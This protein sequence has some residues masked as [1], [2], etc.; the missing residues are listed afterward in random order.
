MPARRHTT[1]SNHRS[2]KTARPPSAHQTRPQRGRAGRDAAQPSPAQ[3]MIR[4]LNSA[5]P[6]LRPSHASSVFPS[7][8]QVTLPWPCD[9]GGPVGRLPCEHRSAPTMFHLAVASCLDLR[10]PCLSCSSASAPLLPLG[11]WLP[12]TLVQ[13]CR[14]A[15]QITL[16]RGYQP[17]A[18]I[19]CRSA[20]SWPA[21]NVRSF[22]RS[23]ARA[24]LLYPTGRRS[25]VCHLC[26]EPCSATCG[27]ERRNSFETQKLD[28]R[29]H[30][31]RSHRRGVT[32]PASADGPYMVTAASSLLPY[33]CSLAMGL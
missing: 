3:L 23:L 32:L 13:H 21:A 28:T 12:Q 1:S 33:Y 24:F 8:S 16:V 26:S 19:P 6:C 22:V 9:D 7:P 30:L 5:R 14:H 31:L 29:T 2:R 18:I 4:L 10:N 17:D 27:H 11:F 15:P 25:S 20:R